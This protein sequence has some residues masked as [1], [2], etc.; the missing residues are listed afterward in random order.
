MLVASCLTVVLC[1]ETQNNSFIIHLFNIY[2][3]HKIATG[4][5]RNASSKGGG[6]GDWGEGGAEIFHRIHSMM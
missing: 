6:A 2:L 4:K 5:S 1:L 3:I